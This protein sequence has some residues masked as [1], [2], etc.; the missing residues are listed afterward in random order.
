LFI[1]SAKTDAYASLQSYQTELCRWVIKIFNLRWV[2][3]YIINAFL[4]VFGHF[5]SKITSKCHFYDDFYVKYIILPYFW[6][7]ILK[8]VFWHLLLVWPA[9]LPKLGSS[10]RRMV[11][12][13]INL[14]LQ[15]YKNCMTLIVRIEKSNQCGLNYAAKTLCSS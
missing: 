11:G 4:N 2:S 10:T 5:Q 9:V 15:N 12:I 13:E 1:H 6:A 14:L 8:V 3:A 7:S